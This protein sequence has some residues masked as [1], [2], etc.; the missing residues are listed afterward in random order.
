MSNQLN[1]VLI[2]A[3]VHPVRL[4]RHWITMPATVATISHQITSI[5]HSTSCV[6]ST[7]ALEK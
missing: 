5:S 7:T 4:A 3:A 1:P 2:T 6:E